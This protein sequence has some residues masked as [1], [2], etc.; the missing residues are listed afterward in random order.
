MGLAAVA[1]VAVAATLCLSG[2]AANLGYYWQSV[3]GHL[4]IMSAARPVDELVREPETSERLRER[5]VLSQRIRDFAVRELQLPDNPSY[6]R[7]ADL[8]RSAAVWN[9]TA[10]PA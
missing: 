8:R 5:L 7:Y 9:V 2:C 4:Q 1:G 3:S 10:A 6:R